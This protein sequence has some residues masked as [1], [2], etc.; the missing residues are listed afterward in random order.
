MYELQG[1]ENERIGKRKRRLKKINWYENR[2]TQ[3]DHKIHELRTKVDKEKAKLEDKSFASKLR[4]TLRG[5]S[6][7]ELSENVFGEIVKR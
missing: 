1:L 6:I 3:S 7:D 2:V 4:K 5:N